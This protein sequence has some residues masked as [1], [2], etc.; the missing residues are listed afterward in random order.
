MSKT[1][2]CRVL[3]LLEVLLVLFDTVDT[4][5]V[6]FAMSRLRNIFWYLQYCEIF[7]TVKSNNKCLFARLTSPAG[8]RVIKIS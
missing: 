1:Q 8:T 7:F 4:F 5:H 6:N 3:Y 2:Q